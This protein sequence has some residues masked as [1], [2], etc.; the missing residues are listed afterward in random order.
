MNIGAKLVLII[1]CVLFLAAQWSVARKASNAVQVARDETK[2][3]M[4]ELV[5]L[6]HQNAEMRELLNRSYAA[7]QKANQLLNVSNGEYIERAKTIEKADADWLNCQLP[8]ELRDLFGNKDG[9][10]C[11][12]ATTYRILPQAGAEGAA[13]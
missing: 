8:D 13:D 9:A 6:Q 12:A 7:I 10:T 1:L 4:A 5:E 3:V 11:S 2:A